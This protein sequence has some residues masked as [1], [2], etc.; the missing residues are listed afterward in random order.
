VTLQELEVLA[1]HNQA[2][3]EAVD[4][5]A[6]QADADVSL[7][8]A[9]RKPTVTLDVAGYAAPGSQIVNVTTADGGLATVRASPR[10][11]DPGAFL[12]RARYEGII[13]L[14][15]PLYDFG[16]TKAAVESA[17]L[18]R[19]AARARAGASRDEVVLSVRASY[20]AWLEA[21]VV[22]RLAAKSAEEAKRERLRVQARVEE[23]DRPGADL[24]DA[25]YHEVQEQLAAAEA[26]APLL[27]ARQ[28][29]EYA[30]G[31]KLSPTA[32]PDLGLLDAESPKDRS[33]PALSEIDALK[34]ERNAA[35][36]EARMHRTTRRPALAVSGQ[37]GLSG[38]DDNVFP[39]YRLGMT[40]AVPLYDG[41]RALAQAR[42]IDAHAA[43]LDA[44][45]QDRKAAAQDAKQRALLD[46]A[47][48]EEQLQIVDSL[49]AVSEKRVERAEARYEIG[50]GDLDAIA[51]ARASLRDAESR[52]VH[53][54]VART[55]A[56][57]RLADSQQP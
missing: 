49:V 1:L 13:H 5:R 14:S 29:L 37:T 40:L 21:H 39:M 34:R 6:A 20:L 3:W 44:E 38:I 26:K 48:A 27:A 11:S 15:A 55:D 2:Q 30:V 25:R 32:V 54:R 31:A 36:L 22:H 45:L 24:D 51:S 53:I 41:G 33:S 23:G 47:Q 4:A 12:A 43:E 57:F 50:A 28:Q 10:V 56:M 52:R 35:R 8:K 46:R 9:R 16:R 17:R 42:A 18:Y 7:A 19:E